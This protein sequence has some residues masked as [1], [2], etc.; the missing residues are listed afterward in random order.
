[1]GKGVLLLH[2]YLSSG[3]CMILLGIGVV[4][5]CKKFNIQNIRNLIN[6]ILLGI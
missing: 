5:T 6:M 4:Q 3:S 1:M 2:T